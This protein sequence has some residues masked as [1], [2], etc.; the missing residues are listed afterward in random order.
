MLVL[1][2]IANSYGNYNY[3]C[4]IYEDDLCAENLAMSHFHSN[5]ELIYAMDGDTEI[6]LNGKTDTLSK[7]ELML[8][9]PFVIHSLVIGKG[10]RAWVGVFS[11]DF[12]MSFAEKNRYVRYS[13]FRCDE[14]IEAML[15]GNLFFEGQPD[16]YMLKA[17]LYM[18]IS[19]CVKNAVPYEI[20]QTED[21]INCVTKYI[22]ENLGEDIRLKDIAESLGYEYHYFSS[23]FHKSFSM[24]FKSFINIFRFESACKMLTNKKADITAV[25][26][27]CGFG[28]T[29]NFN[30]VFKQLSGITPSEYKKIVEK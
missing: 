15:K 30:R 12:I 9:S 7:G 29:R 2:Q 23:L 24:N 27:A 25:C 22:S 13:K 1:H 10:A 3:N 17:C 11:E 28:S 8:V 21:F 26:T 16:R 19:E 6:T 5:Y 4:F 18:V 14:K 20:R